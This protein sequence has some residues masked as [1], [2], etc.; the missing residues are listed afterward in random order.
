MF[1]FD[2]ISLTGPDEYLTRRGF[3]LLDAI[4][5]GEDERANGMLHDGHEEVVLARLEEDYKEW[6]RTHERRDGDR[7]QGPAIRR[8]S[9]RVRL[10]EARARGCATY[11]RAFR[12]C[13]D[14]RWRSSTRPGSRPRNVWIDALRAFARRAGSARRFSLLHLMPPSTPPS[15]TLTV[16]AIPPPAPAFNLR[17][18]HSRHPLSAP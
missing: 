14:C 10:K 7:P 15:R 1:R 18:P 4:L 17:Q 9:R 2:G 11:S 16:G 3:D 12:G 8:H 5:A 13:R 6:R